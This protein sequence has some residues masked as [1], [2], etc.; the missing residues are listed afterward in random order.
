MNSAAAVTFA[1]RTTAFGVKQQEKVDQLQCQEHQFRS[2]H[3]MLSFLAA[4]ESH[5]KWTQNHVGDRPEATCMR[6]RQM[7]S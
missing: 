1:G 3:S 5:I 2:W 7:Y 6:Y 4:N